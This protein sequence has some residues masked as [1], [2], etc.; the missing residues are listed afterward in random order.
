MNGRVEMADIVGRTVVMV[1]SMM[2]AFG[3]ALVGLRWPWWA[4]WIPFGGAAGMVLLAAF[5]A[6]G[7]GENDG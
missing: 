1:M 4:A 6:S 2:L 3:L 5:A 7:T